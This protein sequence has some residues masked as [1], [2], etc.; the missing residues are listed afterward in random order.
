MM[1]YL[2]FP[3]IKEIEK[4]SLF[5]IIGRS[6][7][8]TTLLRTL[9][10]AHRNVIVPVECTFILQL[11][12]KYNK[13]KTWDKSVIDHFIEDIQK[14]WL[15]SSMN[16]DPLTLRENLYKLEGSRNYL[17][18]CKAVIF[19]AP[20]IFPKEIIIL[21]GDKNPSYSVQFKSL[22]KLF[23]NNCKYINLVRD[24]R[25]QYISLKNAGVEIPDITVSTKRWVN[26]YKTIHCLSKRRRENFHFLKYED[27]V[28]KPDEE[29]MKICL[30][31]KI[32]FDP[33]MLNFYTRKEDFRDVYSKQVIDGIHQ[34]LLNPVNADKTGIWKTDLNNNKTG[35]ADYIAGKWAEMAGYQRSEFKNPIKY[36]ILSMPG[37]ILYYFASFSGKLLAL[38][39]FKLYLK[40]SGGAYFGSLW[41]KYIRKL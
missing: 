4:I 6:R 1:N 29:L 2:P 40:Y 39:P 31:L 28:T 27:L 38:A 37:L 11:S 33:E 36:L 3:D 17:T 9:L 7:S 22:Y 24:Y 35:I 20:V 25:D 15:F 13:I 34:R 8:G 21:A 32:D 16:I 10:D 12:R 41:N 19:H 30:F 18:I 5:F 14:T 23:G 26:S